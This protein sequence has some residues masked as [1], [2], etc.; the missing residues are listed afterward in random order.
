MGAFGYSRLCLVQTPLMPPSGTSP[1]AN[2][3]SS[4]LT[5]SVVVALTKAS[6][7]LFFS[8][9][10][11]NL[12]FPPLPNGTPAVPVAAAFVEA[13]IVAPEIF[14]VDGIE[15]SCARAFGNPVDSSVRSLRA[16]SRVAS[17]MRVKSSVC[18]FPFATC[19]QLQFW[20][21]RSRAYLP[22]DKRLVVFLLSHW[23]PF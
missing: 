3:R 21:N 9:G 11:I 23:I 6:T 18:S 13:D 4:F 17:L 14:D 19:H 12:P 16:E 7:T 1:S 2:I 5:S 8:S 10:V 20:E 22:Y 15:S